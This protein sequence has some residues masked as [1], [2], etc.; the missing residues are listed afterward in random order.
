MGPKGVPDTK[1]NWS[2]DRRPQIKSSSS[3]LT[4]SDWQNHKEKLF[5]FDPVSISYGSCTD[6]CS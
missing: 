1:M 6:S 3:S 2:T 4:S 5:M